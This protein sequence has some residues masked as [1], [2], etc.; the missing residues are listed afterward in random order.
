MRKLIIGVI[1]GVLTLPLLGATALSSPTGAT[2]TPTLVTGSGS[3]RHTPDWDADQVANATTI[4]RVGAGKTIPQHG[5]VIAVATAIQESTLRNLPGGDRDSIG[6][7]QQRPSQG[8]GTPTQ[9]TDPA[10]QATTF[11]DTLLAVDGWQH[12]PLTD[13]A[14]AVQKSAYPQ[15]YA[16]HTNTATQLVVAI[17]AS[18]DLPAGGSCLSPC[19]VTVAATG[20]ACG[21]PA[22]VF[23][24]A[25]TWLTAWNGGPVPYL[26]S[27]NPADWHA[28]YRRDCSG[29]VSMALGLPGPGLN[30]AAL[31]ARSQP[32]TQ[33]DL[34]PGDLLINPAPN[35]RGHVVLF[36]RWADAAMTRYWGYEQS[37]SGGTHYHQI[38]YPY[39]GHYPMTAYRL[40]HQAAN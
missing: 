38:P 24:R 32:L 22:A 23:D 30:T 12:L 35:L 13:A 37:G 5:W 3:S 9:L 2:C 33:A 31:A 10:Y 14:Q 4:V 6:L 25:K 26:S 18:L 34:Q 8:W 28:G 36:E 40:H 11:Y 17:A 39:F 27:G 20:T 21:V 7:F 15:A 1:V 16:K 29:Y 19:T